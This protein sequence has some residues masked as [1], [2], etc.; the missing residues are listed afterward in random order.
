TIELVLIDLAGLATLDPGH[1]GFEVGDVYDG[2][3]IAGKESRLAVVI[4]IAVSLVS[5]FM[6]GQKRVA[7][8]VDAQFYVA[9]RVADSERGVCLSSGFVVPWT[10][11]DHCDLVP[12]AERRSLLAPVAC[13]QPAAIRRSHSSRDA[14]APLI[15]RR[16][17]T[18]T[19]AID[20]GDRP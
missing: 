7:T 3:E 5:D 13:H 18:A 20:L 2:P 16:R 9:D 11:V 8:S 6:E 1:D 10:R 17:L 15:H 12:Q 4:E 14:E 19:S